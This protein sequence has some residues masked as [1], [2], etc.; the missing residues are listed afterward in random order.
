MT[1]FSSL[2]RNVSVACLCVLVAGN[3]AI[4]LAFM[5]DPEAL[6]KPAVPLDDASRFT[7]LGI[8][9]FMQGLKLYAVGGGALWA[10]AYY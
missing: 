3:A 5:R 7:P 4:S 1:N 6:L 8:A 2:K 10:Y 9:G